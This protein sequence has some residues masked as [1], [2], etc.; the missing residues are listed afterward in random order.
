MVRCVG[1]SGRRGFTLIELLVVIA[2]IA[3]LIGLLL[4]AVQK[5]RD[6][7][8]RAEASNNLK[9][10][11]LALHNYHD[12]AV[13]LG[14]DTFTALQG[15]IEQDAVD[16]RLAAELVRRYEANTADL[17]NLLAEM[18]ALLPSR[19]LP[20]EDRRILR[21]AIGA[22]QDLLRAED[23]MLFVL[24]VVASP[25][26]PGPDDGPVGLHRNEAWKAELG[27]L[28]Q[29]IARPLSLLQ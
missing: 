9:Q 4:P 1:G 23:R 10:I 25:D 21:A 12:N 8:N 20:A 14:R 16:P 11:G 22:V 3:I 6:A 13:Q 24:D 17:E 15:F 7:A 19:D 26:T 2:I 29:G 27:R 18:K 28:A 5:V